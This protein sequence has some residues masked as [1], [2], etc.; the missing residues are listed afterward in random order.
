MQKRKNAISFDKKADT[1]EVS[2]FFRYEIFLFN[3]F[4]GG[5]FLLCAGK[6]NLASRLF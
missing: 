2:A 6:G 4:C 5:R 1:S 3:A